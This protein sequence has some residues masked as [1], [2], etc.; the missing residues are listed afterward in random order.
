ML[1]FDLGYSPLGAGVRMLPVAGLLVLS[2]PLSP[3]LSRFAGPRLTIAAGL[4]AIAPVCCG[5]RRPRRR[6][7]LHELCA[8]HDA[9]RSRD[10]PVAAHGDQFRRGGGP[11]G[12]LRDVGSA[13][14]AVSLQVGGALG[15]AVI[16]SVLSTRYQDH[17]TAALSGRHVPS[18]ALGTIL[19]SLGGALD[20]AGMVGGATGAELAR[21]AR[22][23][24]MDANQV[25]LAVGGGVAL[26][27]ALLVLGLLHSPGP[28][29]AAP[30]TRCEDDE[31]TAA[32]VPEPPLEAAE[33]PAP[34][35]Q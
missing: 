25:S 6:G 3:R 33:G 28:A 17:M 10:R 30:E 34:A 32:G 12:R 15:V 22:G 24:F 20:V 16:G 1:Q 9:H 4:A 19:G 14:N 7:H 8:R 11:P 21:L 18:Y 23:A 31:E 5:A 26:C 2:A 27:G 13:S 29:S 35:R